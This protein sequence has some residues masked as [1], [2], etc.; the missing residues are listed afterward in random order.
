[1]S[2]PKGHI[3]FRGNESYLKAG[4]KLKGKTP[5]NKGWRKQ[6]TWRSTLPVCGKCGVRLSTRMSEYCRLHIFTSEKWVKARA[7]MSQAKKGKP[8]I[9]TG[10]KLTLEQ[11]Q[12]L[13]DAHKGK[14]LGEE[15]PLWKGGIQNKLWHNRQRRIR[16]LGNG[17]TH[18][19][20]E[21]EALK[22]K[23]K[24]TCPCCLREE[25]KITLSVDHVIPLSKGGTDNI[26]NIQPLCRSCNSKKQD[27][28][29][30][31]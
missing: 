18:T 30:R 14:Y 22:E 12:K 6:T 28:S 23:Y 9:R 17:G 3:G 20:A 1:M 7:L 21:W 24:F 16:K 13:S 27:S 8:G 31:Y 5:W 4:S 15:N 29:T 25:P 2:F 26:E 19:L 10:T 11:R